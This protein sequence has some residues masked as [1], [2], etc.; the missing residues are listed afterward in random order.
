[1]GKFEEEVFKYLHGTLCTEIESA[2]GKDQV[3]S[4]FETDINFGGFKST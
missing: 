1:M 2:L 4:I 3:I